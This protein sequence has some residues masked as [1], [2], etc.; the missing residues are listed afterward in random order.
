[1]GQL[2]TV[3]SSRTQGSLPNNTKNLIREGNEHC[4]VIN[5]RS[6]KNVDIHVDVTKK[7]LELNSSQKLPQDGSMLQQ[8]SHQDTGVKDQAAATMEGT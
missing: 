1:M 4:K 3:M 2:A 7:G 5:L 8:L 6:R